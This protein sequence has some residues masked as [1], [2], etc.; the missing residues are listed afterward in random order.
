[1]NTDNNSFNSNKDD[2][3]I[4]N[5]ENFGGKKDEGYS[6]SSLVMSAMRKCLELGSKE[7]RAGWFNVKQDK[8]GNTVETYIEDTRKAF[9]EAVKTLMMNVSC[10]YDEEA[11]KKVN[12]LKDAI[13]QKRNELIKRC[14]TFWENL[15]PCYKNELVKKGAIHY[16]GCLDQK[17]YQTIFTDYEVDIYRDIVSEINC[18]ITNRLDNYK[19]EIFEA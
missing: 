14:D 5:V 2:F 17:D 4:G 12:N 16:K 6:H 19:A 3:E 1:M 8:H 13:E 9:I 10:D 15:A 11:K 7:M 18:L